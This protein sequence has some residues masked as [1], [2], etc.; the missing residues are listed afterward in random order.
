MLTLGVPVLVR[1]VLTR[2]VPVLVLATQVPVD[3][4]EVLKAQVHLVLLQIIRTAH[5]EGDNRINPLPV[6]KQILQITLACR[7]TQ[8]HLQVQLIFMGPP[9]M[10][11]GGRWP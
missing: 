7:D 9:V 6:V 3:I 1:V 8:G 10:F 4:L 5:L 2:A 11:Q